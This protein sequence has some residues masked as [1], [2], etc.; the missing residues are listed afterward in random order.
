MSLDWIAALLAV[1]LVAT[2]ATAFWRCSHPCRMRYRRC[3][4]QRRH[5]GRARVHPRPQARH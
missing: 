3:A 5:L 4:R 2:V 1:L